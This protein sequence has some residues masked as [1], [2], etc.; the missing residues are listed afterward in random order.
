M[1][2]LVHLE[3]LQ[4]EVEHL[5]QVKQVEREVEQMD[6]PLQQEMQE[7]L[8]QVVEVEVWFLLEEA[9]DLEDLV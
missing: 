2:E 3:Y 5:P 9:E 1:Q 8:I 4:E 7:Q 6:H